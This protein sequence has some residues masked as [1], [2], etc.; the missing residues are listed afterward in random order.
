MHRFEQA[1]AAA[2]SSAEFWD[3]AVD[4]RGMAAVA[5]LRSSLGLEIVQFAGRGGPTLAD[6]DSH[7]TCAES[8]RRASV[9]AH[10]VNAPMFTVVGHQQ[11]DGLN[12]VHSVANLTCLWRISIHAAA[13]RWISAVK[14]CR[15]LSSRRTKES[16]IVGFWVTLYL[17]WEFWVTQLSAV[18]ASY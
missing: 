9:L 2:F 7:I 5:R 11:P 17:L 14:A 8:M 10:Q 12:Q 15:Q 18:I 16:W 3:Y 13:G 1:A 6:P 4:G